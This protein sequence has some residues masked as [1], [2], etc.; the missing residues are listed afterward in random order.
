VVLYI[1]E[2]FGS[3]RFSPALAKIF[4]FTYITNTGAAFGMLPQLGGDLS[5]V[6]G[7]TILAYYLWNEENSADRLDAVSNLSKEGSL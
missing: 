1:P 3:W 7:V 5:I 4:K 2:E 6:L